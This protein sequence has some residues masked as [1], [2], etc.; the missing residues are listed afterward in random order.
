MTNRLTTPVTE[1]IPQYA[2][3]S[4]LFEFKE[5]DSYCNPQDYLG[6]VAGGGDHA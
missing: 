6:I 5:H 4:G 2:D 3:I 1:I